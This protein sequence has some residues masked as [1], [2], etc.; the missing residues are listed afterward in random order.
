MKIK[1]EIDL[2][3]EKAEKNPLSILNLLL[4]SQLQLTEA[5]KIMA[6]LISGDSDDLSGVMKYLLKYKVIERI[7]AARKARHVDH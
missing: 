1:D 2:M 7:S 4:E 6:N 5:E 3:I